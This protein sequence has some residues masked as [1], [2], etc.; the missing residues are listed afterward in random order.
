MSIKETVVS[1]NVHRIIA[2]LRACRDLPNV[3]LLFPSSPFDCQFVRH[4]RIMQNV[5]SLNLIAEHV[6]KKH[7]LNFFCR[8]GFSHY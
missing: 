2:S 5:R 8:K 7:G 3:Q 6:V 1:E 4:S